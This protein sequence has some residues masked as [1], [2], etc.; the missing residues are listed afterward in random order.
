MKKDFTKITHEC[1]R[2]VAEVLVQEPK[3]EMLSKDAQQKKLEHEVYRD[4][5]ECQNKMHD[6]LK[7]CLLALAHSADLP[8]SVDEVLSEL[9]KAFRPIKNQEDILRLGENIFLGTSWKEQFGISHDCMQSLYQGASF[10]FENKDFIQAEKAFFVIC[11]LDPSQFAYWVGLGH[12][13]YQNKHY[14]QST[15]AYGMASGLDP[16]NAW[17]HIWAANC[18]E[19]EKDYT[20]ASRALHEAITL[21]S[22]MKPQNVNLISSLEERIQ[23]NQLRRS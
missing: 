23:K 4:L 19:E 11:S 15:S 17:P 10:L 20:L 2:K 8:L 7:A 9:Q 13:S 22:S 18:F 12:S 6:G 21:L 1:A 16:K 5:E 14:P 3:Q